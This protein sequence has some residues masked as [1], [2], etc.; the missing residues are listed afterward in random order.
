MDFISLFLDPELIR[1]SWLNYPL[2]KPAHQLP[3]EAFILDLEK[4]NGELVD[5]TD[6]LAT[7]MRIEQPDL[8]NFQINE[9]LTD[10]DGV[11]CEWSRLGTLFSY[12]VIDLRETRRPV[13][14]NEA[15]AAKTYASMTHNPEIFLERN[16]SDF[17]N[18]IGPVALAIQKMHGE[19]AHKKFM[20][21]SVAMWILFNPETFSHVAQ[22]N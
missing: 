10:R 18:I 16:D 1:E 2:G 17:L 13:A 19:K 5:A 21:A 6:A 20:A 9:Q 3:L 8:F 12:Q 4:Y 7:K 22:M 15:R 11:D 14:E